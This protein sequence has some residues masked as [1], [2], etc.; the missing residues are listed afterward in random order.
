M[1]GR[2][3]L[4]DLVKNSLLHISRHV[5]HYHLM[6]SFSIEKGYYRMLDIYLPPRMIKASCLIRFRL[7][8]LNATDSHDILI[9]LMIL[10]VS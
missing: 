6:R 5:T 10:R 9:F 4:I 7:L 2:V 8:D 3:C 1:S